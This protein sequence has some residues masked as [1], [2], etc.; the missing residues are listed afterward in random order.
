M[1]AR[2]PKGPP[3][4]TLHLAPGDSAAG[5][6]RQ[7]FREAG[8]DQ[9]IVALSDDLS[10]GPI[11]T[12]GATARTAWW[13]RFY[14]GGIPEL[15]PRIAA[16][17]DRLAASDGHLVAWVGRRS[18]QECAFLFAVAHELG[19]RPFST[20]DVTDLRHPP[21]RGPGAE[22]EISGAVSILPPAVLRALVG[23]E[24]PVAPEE[25]AAMRERWRTLQEEDGPF[26]IATKAGLASVPDDHFDAD[27]VAEAAA[28]PRK[29]ARVIGGAMVRERALMQV[30]DLMLQARLVALV[31][32]GK[33][34]AD[35]DPWDTRACLVRL[36]G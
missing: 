24:R 35:G 17:W 6:L 26:R 2:T 23:T 33:L 32:A 21:G 22:L 3:N 16:F 28:E 20:I 27:L 31:E 14:D 7:T 8:L 25:H 13:G 12:L 18:A 36:P 4:G 30:G 15:E 9:E 1:N 29:A 5:S 11:R 10:C 34:V 19:D